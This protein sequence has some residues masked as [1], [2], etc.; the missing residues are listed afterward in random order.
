M[1]TPSPEILSISMSGPISTLWGA[2]MRTPFS[3]NWFI[4]GFASDGMIT[5]L[6][7]HAGP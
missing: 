7:P 3:S 1:V 6:L 2:G 4:R 5:G